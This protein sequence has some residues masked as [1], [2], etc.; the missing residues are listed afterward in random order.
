MAGPLSPEKDEESICP[1]YRDTTCYDLG[2]EAINMREKLLRKSTYLRATKTKYAN[3]GQQT[4]HSLGKTIRISQ[5]FQTAKHNIQTDTTRYLPAEN[6]NNN[7][8]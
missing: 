3:Q 6:A 2:E 4:E 1:A 8:P 5:L 7:R